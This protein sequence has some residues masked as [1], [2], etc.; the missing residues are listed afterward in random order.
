M[1]YTAELETVVSTVPESAECLSESLRQGQNPDPVLE[2]VGGI[3][4][5]KLPHGQLIL[6]GVCERCAHCGME[7]TDSVSVERGIG[8]RCSKKGYEEDGR[9]DADEM[10]AM[11]SLGEFP[12]VMKF[13]V[14][15]YRPK[16]VR[17]LMNGL[18][19]IAS[20]NR[21]NHELHAACCDAIESLGYTRLACT[22]RE[23]ISI[24]TLKESTSSPGYLEVK[25]KKHAYK[26]RWFQE[27]KKL[28]GWSWD[29]VAKC[30]LLRIKTPAGTGD[31]IIC[32]G[33]FEGHQMSVRQMLWELLLRHYAGMCGKVIGGTAF[34]IVPQAY[35]QGDILNPLGV[36]DS[37]TSQ[38]LS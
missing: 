26:W 16:G 10:Q 20:L 15:H 7:L 23:S 1:D 3:L 18:V 34:K 33:D 5:K 35:P 28:P 17:G 36:T 19:R 32:Y 31:S 12:E 4:A 29:P 6:E 27:L 25:V 38:I 8:P 24:L 37:G 2:Y 9:P 30:S 21:G 13:L 11:I 22:L 14:D